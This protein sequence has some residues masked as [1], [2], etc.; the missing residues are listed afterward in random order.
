[1]NSFGGYETKLTHSSTAVFP[2]EMAVLR[3]PDDRVAKS[4]IALN[5]FTLV[6]AHTSGVT[7]CEKS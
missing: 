6:G 1:M 5:C 4:I 2:Q 3:M 7:Q